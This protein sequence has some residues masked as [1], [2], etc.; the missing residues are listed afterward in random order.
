MKFYL[1]KKGSYFIPATEDDSVKARKVGQGEVVVV[2]VVDQ[3]NYKH[4]K[5]FFALI[6]IAFSNMPEKYDNHFPTPELLREELI[7][8]AGYYHTYTDVK[9]NIQY[10]ARSISFEK[11]SQDEFSDLY[12]RVL[13]VIIKWFDFPR[14]TIE[15][16]LGGFL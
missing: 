12:S 8:R 11:M 6:N 3:R 15:S 16:E 2:K 9:G 14:E 7:K 13:D 5:K 4:L 1:A 10:V